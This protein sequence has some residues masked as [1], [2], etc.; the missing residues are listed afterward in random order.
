MALDLCLIKLVTAGLKNKDIAKTMRITE[1]AVKNRIRRIFD[2]LG[3]Y[4]RVELAM[5]YIKYK[6]ER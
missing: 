4:N 6:E 3:F 5:W 1:D 2:Q